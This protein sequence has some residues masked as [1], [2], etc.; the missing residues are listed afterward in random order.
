VRASR[1]RPPE[2]ASEVRRTRTTAFNVPAPPPQFGWIRSDHYP[3][4]FSCPLTRVVDFSGKSAREGENGGITDPLNHVAG[5]FF[6]AY[7]CFPLNGPML[8]EDNACRSGG[9]MA[10]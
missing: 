1:A 6:P 2:D 4:H 3:N 10:A 7:V 9:P 8:R 5:A